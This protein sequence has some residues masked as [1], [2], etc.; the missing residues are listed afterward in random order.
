[1]PNFLPGLELSR[2]FFTDH[3]TQLLDPR[4]S[5][6]VHHKVDIYTMRSFFES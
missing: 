3:G 2:L 4:E 1:M 5:G 6:P